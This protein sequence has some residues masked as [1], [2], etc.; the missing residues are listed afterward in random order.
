MMKKLMSIGV[1]LSL[2]ASVVVQ[3]SEDKNPAVAYRES[4]MTLVGANF[5]PMAM[6]AS[7]DLPW[8]DQ[9]MAAYGKDLAAVAGL[10]IMRGFPEGSLE[11]GSHAKAEI[12]KNLAD[13]QKQMENFQREAIKLGEVSASADRAAI[14]NQIGATGKTCKSCHDEY[15]EKDD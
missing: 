14:G 5:G 2:A 6:M 7:G 12:W 11:A 9:R 3:A 10:N 1:A 13:F 8:D 4:L 15:K